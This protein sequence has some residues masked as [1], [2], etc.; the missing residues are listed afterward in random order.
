MAEFLKL[1]KVSTVRSH[2]YR[3]DYMDS[4]E[5]VRL[6]STCTEVVG[7]RVESAPNKEVCVHNIIIIEVNLS[8]A[9]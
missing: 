7:S 9:R 2:F 5:E 1:H 8:F 6:L 3:L 4:M